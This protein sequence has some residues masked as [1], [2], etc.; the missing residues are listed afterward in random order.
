MKERLF[1]LTNSEGNHGEDVKELYYYLDAAP[2]HSYLKML[3]K[4]PQSAFPYGWL[5]SENARLGRQNG[6]FELLDTGI[7][8][9][10]KY[11]DIFIE[12]AR[13]A[14]DDDILIKITAHNRGDEAAYLAVLPTVWFRNLWQPKLLRGQKP[15]LFADGKILNIHHDA[16]GKYFLFAEG[17]ADFDWLACENETNMQRLYGASNPSKSCKDGINDFLISGGDHRFLNPSVS[18]TKAAAYFQKHIE[19]HQSAEF[20][21]RLTTVF[22]GKP[23]ADFASIT[24][25]NNATTCEPT[26]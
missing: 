21:L 4:Y 20:R 3:Y 15:T 18:G 26:R 2:D 12:Y 22:S 25:N 24:G 6:E 14:S 8:D 17:D 13:G 19:A 1:G 9:E 10:K 7:F 11:F 16:L 5:L 23:F